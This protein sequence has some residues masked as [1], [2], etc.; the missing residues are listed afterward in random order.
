MAEELILCEVDGRGVARITLNRP[1]IH[2]AFND[3]IIAGMTRRLR[4]LERDPAVRLVVITGAGK[5]FSAGGDLNW[6]RGM[7]GYSDEQ[8][9]EDALRLADLMHTLDRFAKPTIARVNGAAFG[10][11]VGLI[12]C[13]DIAVAAEH[14]VLCLSEVRI[15]L[16]PAVISPFVVR[17]MGARQ[18]RRFFLTAERIAAPDA[19]AV[20]LLHEVVPAQQLDSAVDGFVDL[21]LLGGPDAI[22]EGKSLIA[23]VEGENDRTV[24]REETARRVAAMRASGEG[25]EGLSAFLE[26]RK[27]NWITA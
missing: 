27:P 18:A 15:G 8:N 1:E 4:D 16:A 13:C 3:E 10:G 19:K 5:S 11:G 9:R 17:A 21:F 22:R 26:K 25:Q 12:A 23:F 6:M 14:A 24:W 20:G 2:N 7:A